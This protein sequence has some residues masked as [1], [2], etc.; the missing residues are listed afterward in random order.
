MPGMQIPADD[1]AHRAVFDELERAA[2][3]TYGEERTAE[4]ALQMMLGR[5]A[6]ALWRVSQE[7][8]EPMG[9]EPLPTHG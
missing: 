7:P 2:L 9:P 8:L 5:A 4:G 3:A 6:T 1:P